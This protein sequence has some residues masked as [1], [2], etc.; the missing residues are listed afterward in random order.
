MLPYI[1]K[2]P[3]LRRP[4]SN[5]RSTNK[6]RRERTFTAVECYAWLGQQ[7]GARTGHKKVLPLFLDL[8]FPCL[9]RMPIGHIMLRN[10][11]VGLLRA[12]WAISLRIRH[13]D[14]PRNTAKDYQHA[15][16]LLAFRWEAPHRI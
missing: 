11:V 8:A 10:G 7:L 12:F 16:Y 2:T 14:G 4:T 6:D 13:S 3:L 9:C 15:V 5:V 1:P